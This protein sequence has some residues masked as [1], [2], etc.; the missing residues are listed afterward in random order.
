[1]S[2]VVTGTTRTANGEIGPSSAASSHP[3]QIDVFL[4]SV[5]VN[6][7]EAIVR[8]R[9]IGVRVRHAP[10]DRRDKRT[11]VGVGSAFEI[12]ALSSGSHRSWV[13]PY[14]ALALLIPGTIALAGA[15]LAARFVPVLPAVPSALM[16]IASPRWRRSSVTRSYPQRVHASSGRRPPRPHGG[17]MGRRTR[18]RRQCSQGTRA[19]GGAWA[20]SAVAFFALLSAAD[21]GL[22]HWHPTI[23]FGRHLV[24]DNELL[25]FLRKAFATTGIWRPF[26]RRMETDRPD[27]IDD[28]RTPAGGRRLR[29]VAARQRWDLL[30]WPCLQC[31]S[32][33]VQCL[34]VPAALFLLEAMLGMPRRR[35]LAVVIVVGLL[36]FAIFNTV[37]GWPKGIRGIVRLA[38]VVMAALAGRPGREAGRRLCVV[39]FGGLGALSILA[40]A[41]GACSF[42]PRPSGWSWHEK[43]RPRALLLGAALGTAMLLVWMLYQRGVLPSHDPVTKFAL[44]GG[45]RLRRPRRAS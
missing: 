21:N 13:A 36:P 15:A 33:R 26:W 34:W 42:C 25:G 4:G 37:Y 11:N 28:R 2:F 8:L 43:E 14:L 12:S 24:I 31:R 44:N 6:G 7:A 9:R 35:A 29:M 30:A 17:D 20:A 38:A 5:N 27:T 32:G 18:G 41:S 39:A 16:S 45:L 23:G 1:M 10:P 40:H 22:G 3:Q 19:G